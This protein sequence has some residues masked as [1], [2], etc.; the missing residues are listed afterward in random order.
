MGRNVPGPTCSVSR[1]SVD[2]PLLQPR[3]SASVKCSPAVGAATA[4][5]SGH[6]PSGSARRSRLDHLAL[7]DVG[8]QRNPADPLQQGERLVR[9]TPGRAIQ[10]PS[11]CLAASCSCMSSRPA[12]LIRMIVSPGQHFPRALQRIRQQPVGARLPGRAPP[13]VRRCCPAA[14]QPGRNH[15]R[16]VQ[17]Q[18]IAGGGASGRSRI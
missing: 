16:V 17:H 12:A 15:P 11:G 18:A 9:A 7:A 4:P 2:P 10:L 1:Q 8:R 5:G 6:R 13:S 3:S 14:H